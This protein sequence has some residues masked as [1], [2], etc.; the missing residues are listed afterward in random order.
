MKGCLA[1]S[2]DECIQGLEKLRWKYFLL[3]QILNV[4]NGTASGFY[5]MGTLSDNETFYTKTIL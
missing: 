1:T 5:E 3:Y 2:S 4:K